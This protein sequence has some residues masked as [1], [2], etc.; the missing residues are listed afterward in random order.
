MSS[1]DV[2]VGARL[3]RDLEAEV[4]NIQREPAASRCR[5]DRCLGVS[6]VG[7]AGV[8]LSGLTWLGPESARN[9]HISTAVPLP[10]GI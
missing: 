2:A 7:E 3:E 10:H 1:R 8:K 9:A 6:Q 4:L 5:H